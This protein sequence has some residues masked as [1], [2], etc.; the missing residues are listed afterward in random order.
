MIQNKKGSSSITIPIFNNKLVYDIIFIFCKY[1]TKVEIKNNFCNTTMTN[2][3]VLMLLDFKGIN[4]N[5]LNE[6]LNMCNLINS[7][8]K[9]G[10]I[11]LNILDDDLRKE[12]N[13]NKVITKQSSNITISNIH[14]NKMKSLDEINNF[15]RNKYS[16]FNYEIKLVKRI[17]KIL[18][19][20]QN[21]EFDKKI[22]R[23]DNLIYNKQI[24][25]LTLFY[26]KVFS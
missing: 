21:S 14:N 15:I 10:G 12:L 13:F 25:F 23:L 2:N 7:K 6:I 20:V 8:I 18:E 9:D 11:H 16:I 3:F 19:E 17:S 1:Y 4:E 5:E 24:E 26:D 22:N